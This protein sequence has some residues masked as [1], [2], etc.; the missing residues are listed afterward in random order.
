M[1][2]PIFSVISDPAVGGILNPTYNFTALRLLSYVKLGVELIGISA[3]GG[4]AS[5]AEP[6]LYILWS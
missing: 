6:I 1:N 4:C 2:N 3:K 5:G